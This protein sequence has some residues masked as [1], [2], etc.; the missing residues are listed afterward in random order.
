MITARTKRQLL[1]FVLITLIGV[2]FVGARYAKLNRLFYDTSYP[3]TA[4]FVDSGGVFAGAEV[5]YRGV[6]VGQVKALDL[7]R[8]GVD[9]V[10]DI[11][12]SQKQI[13]AKTLA[14]VGNKSAVGEQ[15]VELQPQTDSGPYLHAGSTIAHAD[16]RIPISTTTLL[17]NIDQLVNSVPQD[18]LRTVIGQLGTTFEGTGRDLQQIIDTSNAFI[19]AADQ[20]FQ[21]TSALIDDSNVVL[22]TQVDKTSDIKSFAKNLALFSGTLA[23]SDADLRKVIDNGAA[24]TEQ[25]RTFLE[26]NQVDLGQLIN[27]LVTTGQIVVKKLPGIEQ[28][29]V[30]YPYIVEGAYSVLA[31]ADNGAYNADFGL[32]LTQTPPVCHSGYET[33]Q[34]SPVTTEGLSDQ[35][36]DESVS[37]K[38]P[39]SQSDAR[40]AQNAPDN[41]AATAYRAPTVATY[42]RGTGKVTWTDQSTAPDQVTYTGGAQRTF[43]KDSWKWLLLQPVADQ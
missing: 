34:R 4:K 27:N 11:D 28:I 14:V 2:A 21:T 41:R 5:T 43:G 29:L 39:A 10:M 30:I 36:M 12:R 13:P 25:L 38:E 23:G 16:T 24:T 17:T 19:R 6:R 42:D 1:V 31:K 37:C 35:P 32:V 40:G 15:Y 3:V 33:T 8:N 26:E 22:Q 18:D 20:N 9:V 7:T